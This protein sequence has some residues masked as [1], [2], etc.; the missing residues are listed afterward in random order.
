MKYLNG[1]KCE[2]GG[3]QSH[4]NFMYRSTGSELTEH[5]EQAEV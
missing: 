3:G 1:I 5:L 2:G 4:P